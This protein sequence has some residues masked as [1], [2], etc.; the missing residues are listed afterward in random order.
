MSTLDGGRI[1]IAAQA[2]GI[3][4]AS[5]S[6]SLAYALERKS[7]GKFIAYHQ[8]I[9]NYLADMCVEIDCARLLTFLA[10]SLKDKGNSYT[11]QAAEAKLKASGVAVDAALKAIQ[12]HGGY[13]GTSEI[14]RLVIA[15][16]LIKQFSG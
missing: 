7:F 6:C 4:Q 11:R 14:Q 13:E 8:T 2:L 16:Q 10:S 1:G 9:Q 3:A 5:L 12:I 15:S